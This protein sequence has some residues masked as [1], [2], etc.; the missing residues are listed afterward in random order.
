MSTPDRL[1]ESVEVWEVPETK[2]LDEAVWQ[3]WVL[4]GREQ[5]KKSRASYLR[6]AKW[7]VAGGLLVAAAGLW[8]RLAAG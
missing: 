8:S 5:D 1:P 7:T 6:A 4:K 2:P 3:A